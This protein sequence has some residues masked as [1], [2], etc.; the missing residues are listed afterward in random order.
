[1]AT[2][3]QVATLFHAQLNNDSRAQSLAAGSKW[4]SLPLSFFYSTEVSVDLGVKATMLRI[5][6]IEHATLAGEHFVTLSSRINRDTAAGDAVET[7]AT[8]S[9]AAQIHD[10]PL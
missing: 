10:L 3:Q 6:E 4:P 7:I 5:L 8:I 9:T 2:P 1:M